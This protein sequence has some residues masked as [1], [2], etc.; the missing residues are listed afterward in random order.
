MKQN[1]INVYHCRDDFPFVGY[2]GDYDMFFHYVPLYLKDATARV[3]QYAP[4]NFT[5]N[6]NDTYAMQSICAYE[7]A[8]IGMSDF[9][10]LFTEEEWMGF[11]QTLD[12][13]Y[14]YGMI[15]Q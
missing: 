1:L 4:A 12:I 11:E 10:G 7:N 2:I 9:C 5:F 8:Y 13:E 6:L 14:Y 3:N 15:D